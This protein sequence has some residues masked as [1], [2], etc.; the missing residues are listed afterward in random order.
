MKGM[1]MKLLTMLT[2]FSLIVSFSGCN[3]ASKEYNRTGIT[4]GSVQL[5]LIK[6]ETTQTEVLEKFGS[7]NIASTDGDLEVWTYQKHGVST[8]S[9]GVGGSL[10][11][12]GG[13]TSGFS[14]NSRSM[15]LIIKFNKSKIVSDF[16]SRYSSF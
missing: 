1:F 12:V 10:L 16:N 4:H 15:T 6:G 3:T 9:S 13:S 11:L 7:P 5:H 14:Q 2:L 8:K